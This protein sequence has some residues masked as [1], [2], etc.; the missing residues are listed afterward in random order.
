MNKSDN[1]SSL[2]N[3]TKTS[4][5]FFNISNLRSAT[6]VVNSAIDLSWFLLKTPLVSSLESSPKSH[7]SLINS[8]LR[9]FGSPGLPP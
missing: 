3:Y 4:R 1:N 6:F 5:S 8:N 2:H 7:S 9:P